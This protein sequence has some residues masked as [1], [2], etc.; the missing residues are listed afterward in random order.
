ML[1]G[2]PD[3]VDDTCSGSRLPARWRQPDRLQLWTGHHLRPITA[4]DVD[5]HLRAVLESRD[6]LWTRY[7]P[8]LGWPPADLTVDQDRTY[9]E[10]RSA[11]AEARLAFGYGVF[12][13]GET[14]LLGCV[15]IDV[16]GSPDTGVS[17]TWWVTDWYVDTAAERALVEQLPGW[18][19][20]HWPCGAT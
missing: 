1:G 15:D 16:T 6:R 9:L 18:L 10:R 7:G 11:Q 3:Q 4:S 8:T 17:V 2:V 14:E 12:D 5:L 13:L 20:E 19:S